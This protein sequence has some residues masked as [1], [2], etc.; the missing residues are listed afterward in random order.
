MANLRKHQRFSPS[1]LYSQSPYIAHR[2]HYP[3]TSNFP[4]SRQN[5]HLPT[6]SGR[7]RS[8]RSHRRLPHPHRHLLPR[9][10]SHRR[11]QR[12][13]NIPSFSRLQRDNSLRRKPQINF[14]VH[15]TLTYLRAAIG[16]LGIS[17]T[18]GLS[19]SITAS[20]GKTYVVSVRITSSPLF[21]T[22]TPGPK[23]LTTTSISRV[24]RGRDSTFS[25]FLRSTVNSTSLIATPLCLG[26]LNQLIICIK[27][28]YTIGMLLSIIIP[29][30]N[31]GKTVAEIIRQVKAVNDFDKEIIVVNDGSTD[32]TIKVIK[33]IKDIT[34][35]SH[36]KNQGKGAAIRTGIAKAAG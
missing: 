3:H 19:T 1:F 33:V 6:H 5:H 4:H 32:D 15:K 10:E 20:S 22:S 8:R 21:T 25:A 14:F 23:F 11:R 29:V 16:S 17:R 24:I 36:K 35:I 13:R 26:R 2:P 9:L 31:E 12:N 7:N 34:I 27:Y 30:Y 28:Y 18:F